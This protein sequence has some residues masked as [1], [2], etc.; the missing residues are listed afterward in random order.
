MANERHGRH[1]HATTAPVRPLAGHDERETGTANGQDSGRTHPA[2][3]RAHQPSVRAQPTSVRAQP[4]SARAH[5]TSVR[6]TPSQP[7]SPY[8]RSLGTT[9]ARQGR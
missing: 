9:S 7:P 4:T 2:S 6:D 5:P 8:A 3:A 1:A